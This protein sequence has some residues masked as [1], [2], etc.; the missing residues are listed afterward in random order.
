MNILTFD[1]EEWFH[2]LDI[3]STKNPDTWDQY[4]SR[5]HDNL[6]RILD[7]LDE[8]QIKA[9]FFCLG[10]IAIK[11]P[12]EIK[13]IAKRGHEI[14]AHSNSHQL[15][16]EL[17]PERFKIDTA[18]VINNLENLTGKKVISYRAPRFSLTSDCN[19][20][21]EIFSENGIERDSSIFPAKRFYGGF[22]EFGNAEPAIIEY[23]GTSIKEFPLGMFSIL[24]QN[25]AFCGG[26]YFRLFP[27]QFIRYRTNHSNYVM[28]YFHP[29]DFDPQQP[30][31]E[32]LSPQRCFKSYVGLTRS[33]SKFKKWTEDFSF[34]NLDL[35][36]QMIDWDKV[37]IL[38]LGSK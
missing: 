29:R 2:L 21:F 14:G 24:G 36:D 35:A 8:K 25:I 18:I 32:G 10:W 1:V 4:P 31:L 34:V 22:S 23:G 37:K 12:L 19:W 33:F 15:L 5:I 6:A 26:G 3:D 16:Y 20:A 38:H 27:Y 30:M 7:Y 17:G 13:E 28:S 11:H 9:T